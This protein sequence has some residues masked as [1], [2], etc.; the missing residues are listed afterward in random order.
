MRPGTRQPAGN[1]PTSYSTAKERAIA[2]PTPDRRTRA[3][4]GNPRGADRKS[5]Q[6]LR[7]R[8]IRDHPFAF[9]P[10]GKIHAEEMEPGQVPAPHP[11]E[12]PRTNPRET[13]VFVEPPAQ[14]LTL[15]GRDQPTHPQGQG[16]R[17]GEEGTPAWGARVERA[18]SKSGL[19]RST[20]SGA[21]SQPQEPLPRQGRARCAEPVVCED[22]TQTR[23][24]PPR[25]DELGGNSRQ[26]RKRAEARPT[27]SRPARRTGRPDLRSDR[28]KRCSTRDRN[29]FRTRN[30]G[31]GDS[32]PDPPRSDLAS[33]RTRRETLVEETR[34]RRTAGGQR[35]Q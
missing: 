10:Q 17:P 7:R 33:G 16:D 29:S 15:P 24:D 20:T 22:H 6:E 28:R 18:R 13:R 1:G 9:V 32:S 23:A 35:P 4:R 34:E 25:K 19:Q 21:G 27:R 11:Q 30:D 2:P 8:E 5:S 14:E 26:G 3:S 12:S 31:Y